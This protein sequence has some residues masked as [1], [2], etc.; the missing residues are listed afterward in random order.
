MSYIAL[1]K[2]DYARKLWERYRMKK[3]PSLSLRMVT[4][5]AYSDN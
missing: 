4:S 3:E 1:G 2:K 5:C